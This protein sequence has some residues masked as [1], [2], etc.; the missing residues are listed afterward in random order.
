MLLM[1][2]EDCLRMVGQLSDV[3]RLPLPHFDPLRG[4]EVLIEVPTDAVVILVMVIVIIVLSAFF[5]SISYL[6]F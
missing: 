5:S 3:D 6:H 1:S 2:Q 4:E